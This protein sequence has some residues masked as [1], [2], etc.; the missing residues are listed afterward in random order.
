MGRWRGSHG[1]PSSF[2]VVLVRFSLTRVHSYSREL[3]VC[4][5]QPNTGPLI[6]PGQIYILECPRIAQ[7]VFVAWKGPIGM[8]THIKRHAYRWY[9]WYATSK[10][11]ALGFSGLLE[12][13]H[14]GQVFSVARISVPTSSLSH[15]QFIRFIKLL[16]Q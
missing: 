13:L 6:Y 4:R 11:A 9:H 1:F 8:H 2:T 16:I 3:Q 15:G 10:V 7:G 12:G 5:M 14:E